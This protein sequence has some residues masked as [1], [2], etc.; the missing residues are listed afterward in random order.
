MRK[1]LL[2]ICLLCITGYAQVFY[3]KA[4]YYN[5]HG[6]KTAS[7]EIFN[8]HA[9]TCA[10]RTLPFGTILEVTNKNNGKKVQVKVT[11]RGPYGKG[12]IIDLSYEA[13]KRLDMLKSGVVNVEIKVIKHENHKAK[14]RVADTAF[15]N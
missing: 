10:H 1:Y 12:K 15:R 6:R 9:L 3:G 4:T 2:F 8:K 5:L 7:G 14:S 11:D 13:A